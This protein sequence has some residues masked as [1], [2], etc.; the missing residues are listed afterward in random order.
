MGFY[1][2]RHQVFS[3]QQ[4]EE[5][6]TQEE[7]ML[8]K[9]ARFPE[10][11]TIFNDA[12]DH[13]N[14]FLYNSVV[15]SALKRMMPAEG[16]LGNSSFERIRE[17]WEKFQ[18]SFPLFRWVVWDPVTLNISIFLLSTFRPGAGKFFHDMIH[19][20]LLP[21]KKVNISLFFGV[22]FRIPDFD[23]RIY[24]LAEIVVHLSDLGEFDLAL[25]NLP[26][27]ETEVRLGVSSVYH[28]AKIL[29]IKGLLVDEKTVLIQEKIAS[30]LHN[31][32]RDFDS[33][34]F[35][36]MQ[37]FLVSGRAEFKAVR[38]VRQMLRLICYFYLMRKEVRQRMEVL[39]ER[40]HLKLKLGF[41]RL[42]LPLGT[43]RV[44]SVFVSMNFLRENEVFEDRHLLKALQRFVP[45][46]QL[47]A[48][49]VFT[50]YRKEERILTLYIEVTK[51]DGSGFAPEEIRLL[52]REL[53][54]DLKKRVQQ[55][56]RPVFMPRNEEEVMR[57]IVTLSQELR[58]LRDIP[59]VIISFDEH[60]DSDISFTVIMLR[61]I[62]PHAKSLQELFENAG[63]EYAFAVDRVKQVGTVWKKYPKEATVF[64]I[65]LPAYQFVRGDQSL[66]L[67]RARQVV[68]TEL[69]RVVG[70]VRDYNGGMISR[71]LEVFEKLQTALGSL[72]QQQ[73]LLLE[74]FFHS[75]LPVEQK[76]LLDP[77]Y[78]K[79]LFIMFLEM[80]D[81]ESV[82]G[83]SNAM[84]TLADTK[85]LYV[86]LAV[87]DFSLKNGVLRALEPLDIAPA[88]LPTVAV[89][90]VDT[91]YFGFLYF[92]ES[93]EA[94]EKLILT[95]QQAIM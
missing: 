77:M 39:P 26:I 67:F 30:L 64:R 21:G 19:R 25:R 73:E 32:P 60:T 3:G 86:M 34:I 41:T 51:N 76:G 95:L 57:N 79:T 43:R 7:Y 13:P 44:L 55:L 82:R 5:G 89:Q 40:R 29:E 63:L 85:L 88:Q 58:Y 47:V 59:Q 20:W 91:L 65:R 33:D 66:D 94:R 24:T 45:M 36:Q 18:C 68:L 27:L 2:S 8:S 62:L 75:I 14:A 28:A 4:D 10:V 54:E 37:H 1:L 6:L 80:L 35:T 92:S 42:H 52:R 90:M 69:Q 46:T 12:T 93:Q 71:Q 15:A 81:K 23:D 83:K 38:E 84:H 56:I 74:N 31:R 49:S 11:Q 9:G 61:I 16:I 72:A 78:I 50:E 70:E 17:E 48:D 53:G 22:D 87:G